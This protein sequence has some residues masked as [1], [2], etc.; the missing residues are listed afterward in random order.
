MNLLRSVRAVTAASGDGVVDWDRAAEAAKAGTDPGTLDLPPAER[1]GYATDV[2]DARDRLRE[3]ADV[4]FDV[5]ETV[6]IQNRHHWIDAN[7]DTFRAVMAPLSDRAAPLLPDAS[8]VANT[9]TM[10]VMLGFLGRNV[11]GQYDP[12]LLA[13]DPDAAH[14]LYFVHPNIVDAAEELDV[15]YPRF[16]RWIAFHEVT[17]AAEFGA[18]PWLPEYLETRME[19]GV[20]ALT[21]G[22]L[23]REAFRELDAAMTAV[24][25][26]AELLMDHAFDDEYA[27]LRRKLDARRQG[28]GPVAKLVRRL[29]GLGLKR[30]QYERGAAFFE[31]VAERRSLAAAGAVWE[32]PENLPTDAELDHPETWLLRVDP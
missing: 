15:D 19:E 31:A 32:R 30:R 27:D 18:A 1:E 4:A 14:G 5:P 10:A 7:L 26:Y 29:L 2:R 24:E 23:D 22:A 21:D 17:H 28:G 12:L 11:L 9:G 16:R 20:L 6:E 8:R 3:T 13:D 25:G